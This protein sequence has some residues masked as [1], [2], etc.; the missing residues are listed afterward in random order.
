MT[1]LQVS[2]H[3]ENPSFN[4]VKCVLVEKCVKTAKERFKTVASDPYTTA[5]KHQNKGQQPC[6]PNQGAWH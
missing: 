3:L 1:H 6:C 5:L 2:N 4:K